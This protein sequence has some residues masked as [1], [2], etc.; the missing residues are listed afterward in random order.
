MGNPAGDREISSKQ[1]WDEWKYRHGMWVKTFYRSLSAVGV[2][3]LLPWIDV[4]WLHPGFFVLIHR[5]EIRLWY[6][7]LLLTLFLGTNT[8]LAF[9]YANLKSV[10]Q[11]LKDQR[12]TPRDEWHHKLRHAFG[13]KTPALWATLAYAIT[14]LVVLWWAYKHY[15]TA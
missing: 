2:F 11:K 1:L 4:R 6:G 3:A 5:Q 13:L 8:H 9:E 12:Q 14:C 15:P 10:E 7:L